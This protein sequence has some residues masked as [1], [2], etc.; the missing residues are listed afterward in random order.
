MLN[1]L[2]AFVKRYQLIKAGDRVICA[3]SG[4]ADSVALTFAMY[5]LKEKLG[6]ILEAAHYNH[7]LRG[8]ESDRDAAFV[9][10]FCDRYDI[11]LHMGGGQVNAGKKGLEAAAR[12]ARYA[13]FA[14]LPGKIATA[15]TA[16][17]NAETVLMHMVRGTGLRGL[18]GIAPVR[19]QVIRPMLEITRQEVLAFLEEYHL[20]HVADSSNETDHF[21]RNRLR[22]SVMPLLR[23]E[24]P[25][26]AQNLSAMALRLREDEKTIA[27]FAQDTD[28]VDK[29]RKMEPA[30][31]SRAIGSFLRQCG[32]LEPE[33]QHIWQVEKLIFSDQPSGAVALPGGVT[34][35]R[36]YGKLERRQ[37]ALP[38][39][40]VTLSCPGELTVGNWRITCKPAEALA[41]DQARFTVQPQGEITVRCRR[42]G[43]T[44]RLAGGTKSL[45]KLFI[46][47]KI[48]AGQRMQIPVLADEA[49]VLGVCG[50]GPNRD[51][52]AEVLPAIEISFEQM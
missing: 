2:S 38:L 5:L 47:R 1:K 50:I 8:E 26:L 14:E 35:C 25:N 7:H 31:R 28:E 20:S 9:K 36:C 39:E 43:D 22:H 16:D 30:L 11:P 46:D 29:L 40:T 18:G 33:A 13:F 21:L 52:L 34:V 15:H 27:S 4:G 45:K 6:I 49:G 10:E 44:I 3:L 12:D 24:N 48:P 17:D 42:T 51:R 19:G 32:V 37:E 41:T 23:A